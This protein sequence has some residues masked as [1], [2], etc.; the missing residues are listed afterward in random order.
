VHAAHPEPFTAKVR[1]APIPAH[2]EASPGVPA[3]ITTPPPR[4]SAKSRGVFVSTAS[5]RS[6]R[7]PAKEVTALSIAEILA[8]LLVKSEIHLMLGA[9]GILDPPAVA[10]VA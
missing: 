8:A 2:A 3:C 6:S 1:P 9:R 5:L 4:H 7:A 10:R